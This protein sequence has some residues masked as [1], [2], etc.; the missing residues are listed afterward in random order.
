MKNCFLSL[1]YWS[2]LMSANP[3]KPL[4]GPRF[5]FWGSLSPRVAD[6]SPWNNCSLYKHPSLGIIDLDEIPF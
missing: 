1:G 6:K 2:L 4:G 3:Q 5:E